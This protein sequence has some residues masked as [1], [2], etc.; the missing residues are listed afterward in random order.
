MQKLDR[1]LG[2]VIDDEQVVD[3]LTRLGF[4][5]TVENDGWLATVPSWR[6]DVEIEE[7]L[8]KRSCV[9]TGIT[10]FQMYLYVPSDY[11]RPP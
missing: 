11:D 8:V 2:H 6:F 4:G 7:D 3:S 10:I 1:L 9:F 5:V